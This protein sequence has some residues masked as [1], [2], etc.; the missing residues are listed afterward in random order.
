MTDFTQQL[1]DELLLT[2]E[3]LDLN[4]DPAIMVD[5][6]LKLIVTFIDQIKQKLKRY[7]F[8]SE[9]D[10]IHFFK[11]VLPLTLS[12]HIYY[13]DKIELD[14][15]E[16]RGSPKSRYEFYDQLFTKTETF[17][18]NNKEFFEYCRDG[19]TG[20]DRFYFL[21][22]SPKNIERPYQLVSIIDPD[23]PPFHCGMVAAFLAHMKLE[24][25][26]HLIIT[27]KKNEAIPLKPSESGLKWTDKQISL[28]EIGY[29]LKEQGSFNDGEADLTEIFDCFEK[30]F[31]VDLGNTSRLFQDI[32]SRKT[33]YTNFL[34]L[35]IRKLRKRIDD[36]EDE[37]LN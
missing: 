35:L 15:I 1:H 16:Q 13:C 4:Y 27:G 11:S 18:K 21:R 2:L 7:Q 12:L 19:K 9:E 17:R 28:I 8:A 20:L 32:L 14:R 23:S 6:R 25:E 5:E 30:V 29:A 3:D 31:D 34:D 37:N 22:R 36:I 33:G 24:Q 26:M 10:E